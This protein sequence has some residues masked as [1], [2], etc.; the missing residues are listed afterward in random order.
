M[1]VSH[2]HQVLD[3]GITRGYFQSGARSYYGR[4]VSATA[5]P[6]LSSYDAVAE[7][8]QAIVD[9]EGKRQQSEGQSFVAMA[10][11]SASEVAVALA[12]FKLARAQGQQAQVKTDQQSEELA[13]L[14]SHGQGNCRSAVACRSL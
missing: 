4:D 3:M 8:A 1:F 2:F 7:A 5:L 12:A 9:G 14:S 11:P 13:A 6:D 10:L